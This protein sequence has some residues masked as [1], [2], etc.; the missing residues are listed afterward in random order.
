MRIKRSS[1][2]RINFSF[3]PRLLLVLSGRQRR[4][5]HFECRVD[6]VGTLTINLFASMKE[7]TEGLF[8]GLFSCS[9]TKDALQFCCLS[10]F[11]CLN[12]FKA[13]SRSCSATSTRLQ[14]LIGCR[15]DIP[16]QR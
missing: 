5:L 14:K 6:W 7:K 4:T 10:Y 13:A 11:S 3:N 12:H 8:I 2:V 1:C 16:I 15:S 9:S